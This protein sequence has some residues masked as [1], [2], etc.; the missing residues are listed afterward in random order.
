MEAPR[1]DYVIYH[2]CPKD[3]NDRFVYCG[4]SKNFVRRVEHHREAL[5]TGNIQ[6][7]YTHIIEHGGWDAFE[8]KIIKVLKN[9]TTIEARIEEDK[10]IDALEFKLN[11]RRAYLSEDDKQNYII[12]QNIKSTERKHQWYEAH[13]EQIRIKQQAYY[14]ENKESISER[15][16]NYYQQHK[17]SINEQQKIY[18]QQNKESISERSKIKTTCECGGEYTKHNKARH[19]KSKN[20][21]AYLVSNSKK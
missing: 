11:S 7:V 5:N 1:F 18:Y 13:K 12:A 19:I 2:I 4:S 3:T 15:N 20:H 8:F 10:C 21:Q 14:Q 17:E 6:L 16:K 9:V